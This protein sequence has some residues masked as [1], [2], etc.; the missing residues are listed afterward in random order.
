MN[1]VKVTTKEQL[2][3]LYEDWSLTL[4]GLAPD[5]ENLKQLLDW[6]KELTPLKREDVYTIEGSVMNRMYGLTGT[7]A[8]PETD[9]TLV[10]VKLADMENHMAVTMPRFNIGG[11]WFYDV[12]ENNRAR[13]DAKRTGIEG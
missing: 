13:E 2:D 4:E 1:I 11:R 5:K 6:V 3:A 8:Y 7:N 10:C 9:C 12:V